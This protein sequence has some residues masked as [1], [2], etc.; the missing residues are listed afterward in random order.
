MMEFARWSITQENQ[1]AKMLSTLEQA[2]RQMQAGKPLILLDADHREGEG[3]FAIAAQFC[4]P[5]LIN[6][7]LSK[8]RGL[9]CLSL[10]PAVAARIGV[11]P[12]VINGESSSDTPFGVPIDIDDGSSGVAASA[13]CA[14]IRAACDESKSARHFK[15]PGHVATLLANP[16]G[17][18][19]RIGHTEAVLDL[20]RLAGIA[21]PGV[22]CEIL[23]AD[24][25][26]AT[27]DQLFAIG[28][29]HAIP[30]LHIDTLLEHQRSQAHRPDSGAAQMPRNRVS[31]GPG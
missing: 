16:H 2:I 31:G 27:P 20:L 9:V 22:L 23:N 7:L 15:R 11:K 25:E 12:M 29:E 18:R 21:G 14:T 3:D 6:F 8:G 28:K 13:R 19:G 24:G 26:I 5:E 1:A 4:T 17:L 30:V 10:P